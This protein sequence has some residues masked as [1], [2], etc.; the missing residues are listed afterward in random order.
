MSFYFREHL[1]NE[2]MTNVVGS[3]ISIKV[4]TKC[5]ESL[6][7]VQLHVQTYTIDSNLAILKYGLNTS[8]GLQ[9]VWYH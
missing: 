6:E 4:K 7:R 8:K 1:I 3:M 2:Y 5:D 9:V